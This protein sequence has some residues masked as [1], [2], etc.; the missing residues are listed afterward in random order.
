MKNERLSCS[1][2]S[3]AMKIWVHQYEP[4]AHT[5]AATIE[6]IQE[7]KFE[8][9]PHPAYSPDL[10]LSD[11]HIFRPLS[12]ALCKHQ[13]SNREEVKDMVHIWLHV[14]PKTFFTGGI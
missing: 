4:Q 8:F 11:Y 14:Q 5:L 1:G 3:Q 12:D 7:T 2:L 6:T 10:S 9:L 13:V